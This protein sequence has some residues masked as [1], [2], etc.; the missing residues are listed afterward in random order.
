MYR[1]E[2][3][4]CCR[5]APP[6]CTY[7]PSVT[8]S[9]SIKLLSLAVIY[10]RARAPRGGVTRQG[11]VLTDLQSL[12]DCQQNFSLSLHLTLRVLCRA[13]SSA[14]GAGTEVK[15]ERGSGKERGRRTGREKRKRKVALCIVK[16]LL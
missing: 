10:A 4:R 6:R 7:R 8:Y 11:V 14:A 15:Q 2:G 16:V 5:R 12:L 3:K 1:E 9:L 13:L